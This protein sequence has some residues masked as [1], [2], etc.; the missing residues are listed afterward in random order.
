[1]RL[2]DSCPPLLPWVTTGDKLSHMELTSQPGSAVDSFR[3]AAMGISQLT[4]VGVRGPGEFQ[5]K[6][7]SGI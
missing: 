1:M 6:P 4:C 3:D 7:S 2:T 5:I